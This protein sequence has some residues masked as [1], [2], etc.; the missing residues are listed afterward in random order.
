MSILCDFCKTKLGGVPFVSG[1]DSHMC[2]NCLIKGAN[3]MVE[4]N[5]FTI[6]AFTSYLTDAAKAREEAEAAKMEESLE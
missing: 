3:A 4:N 1:G 2:H 5:T 6:E